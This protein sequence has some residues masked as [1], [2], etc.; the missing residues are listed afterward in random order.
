MISRIFLS[1]KVKEKIL[2]LY[3][4]V[5]FSIIVVIWS[6][7]FKKSKK[8][9]TKKNKNQKQLK[10][11][12]PISR[13]YERQWPV[14]RKKKKPFSCARWEPRIL[15]CSHAK[16][17]KHNPFELQVP[18]DTLDLNL[19]CL[20]VD[21][22]Q[23]QKRKQRAFSCVVSFSITYASIISQDNK[24]QKSLAWE[25]CHDLATDVRIF[26]STNRVP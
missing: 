1:T 5:F 17:H 7:F 26:S 25:T 24:R 21:R 2:R 4:N 8:Q 10:E 9:I 15:Q 3:I 13:K 18:T 16:G 12:K 23:K 20:S 11:K 22:I 6:H 14:C 19:R